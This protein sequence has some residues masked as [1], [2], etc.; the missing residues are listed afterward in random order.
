MIFFIITFKFLIT[1]TRRL[2]RSNCR[3]RCNAIVA[4]ASVCKGCS[5]Y[6]RVLFDDFNIATT[7]YD[8]GGRWEYRRNSGFQRLN[9]GTA[10][11]RVNSIE[12]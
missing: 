6:T 7:I 4:L 12:D 9:G 8:M 1:A 3:Y 10:E 5:K 2:F 11:A